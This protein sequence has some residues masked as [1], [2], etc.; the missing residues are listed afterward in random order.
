MLLS[1]C[2]PTSHRLELIFTSNL[3]GENTTDIY[4]ILDDSQEVVERLTLTPDATEE[5]LLVSKDGGMVVFTVL[6]GL[7]TEEKPGHVYLLHIPNKELDDIT[8]NFWTPQYG[9][10]TYPTDWSPDLKRFAIISSGDGFPGIMDFNGDSKDYFNLSSLDSTSGVDN[11][12]WSPDGNRL[13]LSRSPNLYL[14]PFTSAVFVY[15]L[16]SQQLVQLT[17]YQTGCYDP[18]WSPTGRQIAVTCQ[19]DSEQAPSNLYILNASEPN[20][21]YGPLGPSPCLDPAW[22]PDGKQLTFVCQQEKQYRLYVVNSDGSELREFKLEELG[23]LAFLRHPIWSP[24]GTQI[25]YVGGID[26]QHT[27]I[28][29]INLDGSNNHSITHQ[30][31]NYQEL[32]VYLAQ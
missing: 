9:M 8:N 5:N 6:D 30:V 22:S 12:K 21:T 1:S 25:I 17:D 18:K 31:A 32:S 15:K 10:H 2:L 28:Y 13:A 27:N 19:A 26:Y 24:D 14:S 3:Q 20:H 4:K 16:E 23:S 11:M 29:S 7:S